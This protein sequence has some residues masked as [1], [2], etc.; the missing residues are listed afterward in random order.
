[1]TTAPT[2][3][4]NYLV[5][6]IVLVAAIYALTTSISS[7]PT[8]P[9]LILI[10]LDTLRA[11]RLGAY[12]Y[13]RDTSPIIDS[14]GRDGA[15]FE[16][17]I[18]VSPWTLPSHV[19]MLTGLF[20][21]SHGLVH[22]KGGKIGKDV[23][24]L[25]EVLKENG[26]RTLAFAGGGYVSKSYGF[27][28]GFETFEINRSERKKLNDGFKLSLDAGYSAVQSLGDQSPFFLFLHTYA[29]HCPYSPPEPYAS[30]FV[31]DGAVEIDP[32]KCGTE[33]NR[34]SGIND[35]QALYLSDRYDGSIRMADAELGD[36]LQKMDSA[37]LLD[38]TYII[39]TSDHG[40]EFLEHGRIGHQFSLYKELL[41]IPLIISGPSIKA[42]RVSHPVGLVDLFAT[43]LDLLGLP[44][45][46]QSQGYSLVPLMQGQ[47]SIA[48]PRFQF[49]ELS[50]GKELRSLINPSS[51]HFITDLD[52][53]ETHYYDLFSDPQEQN[54]IVKDMPKEVAS[55]QASLDQLMSGA[56]KYRTEQMGQDNQK[57]M[58]QLRTLG[59]L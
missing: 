14:L 56:I 28:R 15:V 34:D 30:M 2:K 55:R 7:K 51:D 52:S 12:G 36:F 39:I 50:R 1:M 47:K 37:G 38:N 44:P 8:R 25:A 48:G 54:N 5:V 16:N 10:S 21:S 59:Y 20:P 53:K 43:I 17:A 13:N 27:A 31:S 26:Y 4:R 18:T 45:V 3:I 24:L 58:E 11:D 29:V 6:G 41:A 9:N 19:T 22:P 35:A 33:Y 46:A 57:H 40:E 23:R 42:H 49:S 32:T